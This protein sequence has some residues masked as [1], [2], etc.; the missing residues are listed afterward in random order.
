MP[1]R[2][3]TIVIPAVNFSGGFFYV[4]Y[5]KQGVKIEMAQSQ[6]KR[7]RRIAL[8]IIIEVVVLIF[9]LAGGK[10][11]DSVNKIQKDDSKDSQIAKNTEVK[12]ESGY[13]NIV[14]FGVDSRE[15]ALKEGTNSDTIIIATI[16]NQT[17]DVA[18]TSVYRDT[19]SNIP[20]Y[21]Y[22]KINAAYRNGGYSLALSTLNTNFDLNLK[23]YVTVNF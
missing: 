11:Y 15:N 12:T 7:K 21:G 9:L 2:K 4:I 3:N 14:I 23:E 13:R 1:I 17:K 18:L 19:Y 22:D 16:N 8:L 5:R 6:S 10:V 20:G